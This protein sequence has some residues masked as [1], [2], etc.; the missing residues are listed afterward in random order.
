MRFNAITT[1]PC[2]MSFPRS[3]S[4]FG[5]ITLAKEVKLIIPSDKELNK[6]VLFLNIVQQLRQL[7]SS[8]FIFANITLFVI[9]ITLCLKKIINRNNKTPLLNDQSQTKLK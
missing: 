2:L 9:N 6:K 4:I 7:F 1:A 5:I 3:V 8:L